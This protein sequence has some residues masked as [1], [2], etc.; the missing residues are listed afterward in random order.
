MSS[1]RSYNNGS[2]LCS[3]KLSVTNADGDAASPLICVVVFLRLSYASVSIRHAPDT[4]HTCAAN[5]AERETKRGCN[6]LASKQV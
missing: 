1:Y 6:A 3:H 2:I 4:D 5:S